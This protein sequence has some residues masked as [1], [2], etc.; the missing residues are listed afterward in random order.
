MNARIL[1]INSLNKMPD[2]RTAKLCIPFQLLMPD[3][4]PN[5]KRGVFGQKK[6]SPISWPIRINR[7]HLHFL[8]TKASQFAGGKQCGRRSKDDRAFGHFPNQ[9]GHLEGVRA[10]FRARVQLFWPHRFSFLL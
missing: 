10:T 1:V 2:Y 3:N 7:F 4:Q 9:Y 8:T 6:E 5:N